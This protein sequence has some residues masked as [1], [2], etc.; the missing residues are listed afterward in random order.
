MNPGEG[1]I[2]F[3]ALYRKLREMNFDGIVTN[4]VFAYLDKPE[5]SN[6]VTLKSIREGIK[7]SR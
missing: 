5:W 6:E 2:N 1:E 4:S 3:D 7:Y